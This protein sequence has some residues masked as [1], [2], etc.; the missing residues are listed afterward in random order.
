MKFIHAHH[1]PKKPIR[2]P[3]TPSATWPSTS[4]WCS[5]GRRLGDGDDEAQVEEQLERGRRAERLVRVAH[6]CA[7]ADRVI[8]RHLRECRERVQATRMAVMIRIERVGDVDLVRIEHGKVNALDTELLAAMA[9]ALDAIVASTSAAVITG[10]GRVFSAGVDLRRV[11]DGGAPYVAELI[12]ALH[13]AF[14]AVFTCRRPVVAAI[15]GAAIAGGCIIAAACDQRLMA[16]GPAMIGTTELV[17][18]VPFPLRRSRSCSTRA[19]TGPGTSC[20]VPSRSRWPTRLPPGSSTERCHRTR[21]STKRSRWRRSWPRCPAM[22]T[23]WPSSASRTDHR[24]HRARRPR[25][26]RRRHR[27]VVILSDGG[28][29]PPATRP[30]DPPLTPN[31]GGIRVWAWIRPGNRTIHAQ[32]EDQTFREAPSLGRTTHAPSCAGKH[33]GSGQGD[34][35]AAPAAA[36]DADAEHAVGRGEIGAQP[37]DRRRR[38][39]EVGAQAAVALVHQRA[40][41]GEV[42]GADDVGE[43]PHP[44]VLGDDVPCTPPH[45]GIDDVA[46]RHRGQRVEAVRSRPR[47]GRARRHARHS[48]TS[49]GPR[50]P[51]GTRT[52]PLG[53]VGRRQRHRCHCDGVAVE[54][55][56]VAGDAADRR[57]L[58]EDAGGHPPSGM[59]GGLAQSGEGD[60]DQRRR[61]RSPGPRRPPTP[62]STTARRPRAASSGPSRRSRPPGGPGRRHPRRSG[63]TPARRCAGSATS[64]GTTAGSGSESLVSRHTC[65]RRRRR[66]STVD[67][68]S[69]AIGRH[70]PP[71]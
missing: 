8:D 57:D 55:Q 29:D 5:D 50:L 37:V 65:R 58:V 6:D 18:G 24:A 41:G 25:G 66:P 17:V 47:R 64:R 68:M 56:G 32:F 61:H 40:S 22:P 33:A 10:N 34:D 2:K 7:D 16:D 31:L 59:L 23:R 28:P 71:V 45:D 36:G 42:A 19:V 21:C 53:D 44:F 43:R 14:M 60:T 26:G 69:I 11:V 54:Q 27:P 1:T 46:R 3:T 52:D 12:P 39:L 63:P 67:T 62:R 20:C 9:D 15:D 70:S 49:R 51:V 35:A 38:R 13:R 30:P 4:S 48:P